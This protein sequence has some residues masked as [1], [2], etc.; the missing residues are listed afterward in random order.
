MALAPYTSFD[1]PVAGGSLH[2]GRWGE[3]DHVV[4][5]AHGITGNHFS[6]QGVARALG[7]DV[8]LVAP[9]LRGRGLSGKL[10]APFG[11]RAHADDLAAVLDHLD[12][13]QAVLVGHSMGAYV[14]TVAATRHAPRWSQVVLVDGGLPLPLPL[15]SQIEELFD[16]P[17]AR[18]SD[19]HRELFEQFKNALNSGAVRAA[20]PDARSGTGWRVNAWVKKGILLGFRIGTIVEIESEV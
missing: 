14:A 18:Y 20:E 19:E 17:P 8:S 10:P 3:G 11:M 13:E 4:M 1:V 7:P 15:A 16:R 2:V 6:W 12:L 5:A 9:D